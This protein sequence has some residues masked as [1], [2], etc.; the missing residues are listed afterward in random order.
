MQNL[1]LQKIINM[2]DFFGW[3]VGCIGGLVIFSGVLLGYIF[4]MFKKQNEKEHS[5]LFTKAD[6]HETRVSKIEGSLK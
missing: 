6:D 4:T 1:P 3:L 2:L 5:T